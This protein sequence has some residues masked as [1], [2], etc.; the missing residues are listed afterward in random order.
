MCNANHN[1][2]DEIFPIT[3]KEIAEEQKHDE[4]LKAL[5]KTDKYETLLV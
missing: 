2:N 1:N 3:V 5:V 4:M